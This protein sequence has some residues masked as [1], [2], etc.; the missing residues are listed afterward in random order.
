MFFLSSLYFFMLAMYGI[1]KKKKRKKRKKKWKK[2][3][4]FEPEVI[5]QKYVIHKRKNIIFFNPEWNFY[6]YD[7]K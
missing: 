7:K 3:L 6:N 2:I 1:F 5:T 4:S